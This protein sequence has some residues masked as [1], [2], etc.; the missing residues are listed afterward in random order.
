MKEWRTQMAFKSLELKFTYE[1]L[2]SFLRTGN[3]T[4]LSMEIISCPRH[5]SPDISE[6]PKDF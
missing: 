2:L 4:N 5:L 1:D 6:Y 3:G